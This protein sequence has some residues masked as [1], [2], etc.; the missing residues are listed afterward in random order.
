[1]SSMTKEKQGPVTT[2]SI[3]TLMKAAF[4]L[5]HKIHAVDKI[6]TTYQRGTDERMKIA[7]EV[8]DLRAQRDMI[9]REIK[10]RAGE[11]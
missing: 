10:R 4:A 5:T 2:Q 9:V 6:R 1:V 3:D 7:E 8:A 11:A